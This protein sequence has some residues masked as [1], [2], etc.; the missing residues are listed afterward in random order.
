MPIRRCT[1]K[2]HLRV[3]LC[4]I[5]QGEIPVNI[6][7]IEKKAKIEL[8]KKGGIAMKKMVF[9]V[10]IVFV[11]FF[12]SACA[13]TPSPPPTGAITAE[14]PK[15]VLG[16]SFTFQGVDLKSGK[17]FQTFTWFFEKLEPYQGK[18]AL[19]IKVVS[20][21]QSEEIY[22][23][24][25]LDFNYLATLKQ[26]R[27]VRSASPYFELYKWPLYVGKKW[28]C[29]YEYWEGT[30]RWG[31]VIKEVVVEDF[32]EVKVPAGTFQAF[33]VKVFDRFGW[34]I[35]YFSPELKTTVKIESARK[36]GH[37]LGEGRWI[38]ELISYNI[39]K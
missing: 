39:P 5:N 21:D 1:S 11:M 33:Q 28:I 38:Q 20:D 7:G 6:D 36:K 35:H 23:V 19:W 32:R 8:I 10:L 34:A 30:Q 16:A 25:N 26:G 12:V 14:V 22:Q 18:P 4:Q 24:W 2:A 15:P 27:E 31:D 29:R 17:V 37:R 13:T 9:A 3:A